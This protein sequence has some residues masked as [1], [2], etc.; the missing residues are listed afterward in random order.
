M[1]FY[2]YLEENREA[3]ILAKAAVGAL[4]ITVFEFFVGLVVNVWYQWDVWDYTKLPGN[5]MGQIC[6]KY[7]FIW[8]VICVTVLIISSSLCSLYRA[9][10]HGT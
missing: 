9:F 3:P 1:T 5:I 6:P 2:Y 10:R 7:S 4:I 8:F